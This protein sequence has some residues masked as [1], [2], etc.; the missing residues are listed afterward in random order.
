MSFVS[1]VNVSEND[2]EF[3]DFLDDED[4]S[5]AS[6]TMDLGDSTLET[7]EQT[8]EDLQFHVQQGEELLQGMGDGMLVDESIAV[9]RGRDEISAETADTGR[10]TFQRAHLVPHSSLAAAAAAAI[11]DED[12]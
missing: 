12:L 5:S 11:D 1:E 9:K 10:E 7:L 6:P 8:T 2:D 3:E 4:S